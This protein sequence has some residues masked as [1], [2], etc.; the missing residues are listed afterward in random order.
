MSLGY[1]ITTQL[2]ADELGAIQP[3]RTPLSRDRYMEELG[4]LVRALLEVHEE[5]TFRALHELANQEIVTRGILGSAA[6][7]RE[8]GQNR[9][10]ESRQNR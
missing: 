6:R 5:L 10:S 8:Q 1:I 3:A 7:V 9:M 2:L 4:M